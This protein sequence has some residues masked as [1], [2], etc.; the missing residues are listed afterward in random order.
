MT[1]YLTEP[2]A[3]R[4]AGVVHET[5]NNWGESGK[6]RVVTDKKAL[7]R[8]NANKP[9]R[10]SSRLYVRED[11]EKMIETKQ[12]DPRPEDLDEWWTVREV[13]TEADK[14]TRSVYYAVKVLGSTT[15]RSESGKMY[16]SPDSVDAL[17][18]RLA[19]LPDSEPE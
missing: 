17:L 1:E 2:Q 6:V 13:A 12:P 8:F 15:W 3:A 10:P 9:G 5:I 4:L 11:I 16:I 7:D 14:A 19:P 18:D